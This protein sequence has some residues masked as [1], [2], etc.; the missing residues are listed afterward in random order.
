MPSLDYL[1]SDSADEIDPRT[2]FVPTPSF[3]QFLCNQLAGRPRE[4][5]ERPSLNDLKQ[6]V[7]LRILEARADRGLPIGESCVQLVE[8]DLE[9]AEATFHE[10]RKAFYRRHRRTR[11]TGYD[12][13][14]ADKE[15]APVVR[16]IPSYIDVAAMVRRIQHERRTGIEP[17]VMRRVVLAMMDAQLVS[18]R[19]RVERARV[20]ARVRRLRKQTGLPMDL[21]ILKK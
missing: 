5:A 9:L 3:G 17:R 6:D 21:A 4:E 11:V 15:A 12:T 16:P 20:T 7:L 14:D 2:D 1:R 8:E 13:V 10:L 18:P 19:D